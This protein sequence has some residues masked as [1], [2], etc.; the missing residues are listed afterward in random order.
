MMFAGHTRLKSFPETLLLVYSAKKRAEVAPGVGEATDMF[1]IGP[2]LGSYTE[3]GDHVLTRLK[4]I[5][6]DELKREQKAASKAKESVN[7]YV[8]ELGTAASQEQAT[9]PPSDSGGDTSTDKKEPG[10]E[11]EERKART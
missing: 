3:V 10:D 1:M 11:P 9:I 2:R 4:K 8:E 7:K 5:Y 6:I